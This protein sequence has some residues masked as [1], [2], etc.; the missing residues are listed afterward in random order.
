MVKKIV[1]IIAGFSILGILL[2]SCG[3]SGYHHGGHYFQDKTTDQL[4][5]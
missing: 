3:G 1:L 4:Q 5:N 2:A